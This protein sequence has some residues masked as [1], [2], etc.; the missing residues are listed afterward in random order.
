M[1]SG[2]NLGKPKYDLVQRQ[3][4]LTPG[5]YLS[6]TTSRLNTFLPHGAR[7][8]TRS[9]A[10]GIALCLAPVLTTANTGAASAQTN[11]TPEAEVAEAAAFDSCLT[12]IRAAALE[13]G[14]SPSTLEQTLAS[15]EQLP[16]VIASDRAQPEFTKTFTDYYSVRVS[17]LRVKNGR[18]FRVEHADLWRELSRNSVVPVQYLLAFWGLETNFGSYFGKLYIPSALATLACDARRAEFFRQ[19]LMATF[20][21]VD[22]GH[23]QPTQLVGSWAGAMGHMQF[24]PTTYLEYA[25]DATGDGR[26]DLHGSLADAMYSAA[27]YLKSIGWEPGFRWGR[28]VVV[29]E[30]YDYRNSG[31]DKWQSLAQWAQAGITDTQGNRMPSLDLSAALIIPAGK[32]GPAF[33]VYPNFKIIM[34]WNRSEFYAISVGRLADR[35]A[36]AGRLH[37]PLPTAKISTTDLIDL[38]THLAA[39]GY[40]VGKADGVLGPATRRAIQDYQH[41]LGLVADGFPDAELFAYVRDSR[42]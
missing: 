13:A 19:Q 39:K 10:I 3:F 36:G 15:V 14:I 27:H 32:T 42:S 16:R 23:M 40:P 34:K 35:I 5:N 31:S 17:D 22:A 41:S 20:K 7:S 21:I 37:Q 6:F 12:D 4:E 2:L 38:Q 33:L 11:P 29:P 9:I 1:L 24:M 18:K 25:Q 30:G 28:E 26:A 8:I